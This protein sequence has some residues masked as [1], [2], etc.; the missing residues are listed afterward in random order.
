MYSTQKLEM[1]TSDGRVLTLET[2]GPI[3]FS[4]VEGRTYRMRG[5]FAGQVTLS[6]MARVL[7]PE[8]RTWP[9]Q[10]RQGRHIVQA[11]LKQGKAHRAK[12]DTQIQD[13]LYRRQALGSDRWLE[14]ILQNADF[15]AGYPPVVV[16]RI[17]DG[18]E[19]LE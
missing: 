5:T 19:V 8:S 14:S 6:G 9:A 18:R 11:A 2:A 16:K 10:H 15:Y 4:P 17:R 3:N 12:R 13:A 1:I 7:T